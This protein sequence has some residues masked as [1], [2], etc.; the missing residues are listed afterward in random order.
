MNRLSRKEFESKPHSYW[1]DLYTKKQQEYNEG[2][3]DSDEMWSVMDCI[4]GD[5]GLSLAGFITNE[6][7]R[8]GELIMEV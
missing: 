8:S 7:S 3:I 5:Y 1:L 2:L 4:Y 6:P